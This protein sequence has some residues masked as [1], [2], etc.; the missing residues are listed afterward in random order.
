M[1]PFHTKCKPLS[2]AHSG[3]EDIINA[4]SQQGCHRR[5]VERDISVLTCDVEIKPFVMSASFSTGKAWLSQGSEF[6]LVPLFMPK[7]DSTSYKSQVRCYIAVN[8]ILQCLSPFG[9]L[10]QQLQLR[11]FALQHFYVLVHS[12]LA[13]LKHI[14]EVPIMEAPRQGRVLRLL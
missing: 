3:L 12:V 1:S 13:L 14:Q 8:E 11:C 9:L 7:L 10:H 6:F 5:C 4:S 2:F